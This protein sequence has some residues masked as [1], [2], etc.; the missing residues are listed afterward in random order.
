MYHDDTLQ[1][2][3][4]SILTAP[5]LLLIFPSF[6][7]INI[8][9]LTK[10]IRIIKPLL[11]GKKCAQNHILPHKH[12]QISH[13]STKITKKAKK[14]EGQAGCSYYH[15][16]QTKHENNETSCSVLT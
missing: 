12:L 11:N 4:Q 5:E 3:R 16:H 13:C 15:E 7:H 9:R 2:L 8:Q 6:D 1:I 10:Y 14:A